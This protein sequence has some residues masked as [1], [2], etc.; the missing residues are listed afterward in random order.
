M[1]NS[2]IKKFISS[3]I[4]ILIKLLL[5]NAEHVIS[6]LHV[7]KTDTLEQFILPLFTL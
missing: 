1:Q 4:G 7:R 6:M 3:G 5:S 2:L